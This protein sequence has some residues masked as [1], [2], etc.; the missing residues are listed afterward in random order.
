MM[1]FAVVVGASLVNQGI[2][3][4]PPLKNLILGFVT[5]F[6][7]TGA[8]MVI[9]DYCDRGID[10]VNEPDR[11]IP[12]GAVAPNEALV[13]ASILTLIGLAAASVTNLYCLIIATIAW[14]VCVTY[15]I[16]GK[17][18]G[19][20]GNF[21]VSICI[22]IP[23]L[24]GGF[25]VTNGFESDVLTLLA[26]FVAMAFFS[27]TGREITKGIVDVTG[28]KSRGVR[29]IAILHGERFAAIAASIFYLLAVGLTPIPWLLQLVSFCFL[30]FVVLTDVGLVFCSFSL[31]RNYSRQN[32]RK[33][34]NTV[35]AWFITGLL[36]FI[37]G[38]FG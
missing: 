28:D 32:A 34:K 3:P 29:T 19:L 6:T 36:A 16:K 21:M 22:T 27:N 7:L 38:T 33:T 30:P 9:N 4:S 25:S 35:L 15:N 20:P 37:A 1:G 8:S 13:I 14:L 23:F 2:F 24:Y 12:S 5:S 31:L 17:Y 10:V 26:L 18:T 11:P